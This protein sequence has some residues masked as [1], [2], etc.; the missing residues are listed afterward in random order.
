MWV[1]QAIIVITSIAALASFTFFI[2]RAA[3][4]LDDTLDPDASILSWPRKFFFVLAAIALLVCIYNGCHAMLFWLPDSLGGYDENGDWRTARTG[5]SSV[6]TFLIG[7]SF[8]SF[9]DNSLKASLVLPNIQ[10]LAN[11]RQK[12]LH[13]TSLGQLEILKH[14][15]IQILDVLNGASKDKYTNIFYENE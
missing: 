11:E 9:I 4:Y 7:C 8:I 13:C 10:M 12:I 5:L 2:F 1:L 14:S 6:L 3:F 15:Y